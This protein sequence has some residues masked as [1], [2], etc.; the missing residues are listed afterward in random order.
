MARLKQQMSVLESKAKLVAAVVGVGALMALAQ[1]AG[2]AVYYWD[3]TATGL[4]ATG[5]DWSDAADSGGTTGVV[6]GAAD[7]VVFNQS[8]INGNETVQINA[9]TSIAG[10]TFANTGTTLVD[11]D[12]VT[13][14]QL[15][16][17][18]SGLTINAG[19]GAVTLGNAT[20]V[21]NVALN[22][23]QSW[24]NG[25]SSLLTIVNPLTNSVTTGTATLT[26]NGAGSGGTT[27]SGAINDNGT[28]KVAVNN[29]TTGGTTLF[30]ATSGYTGGFT[31]TGGTVKVA[32]TQRPLGNNQSGVTLNGGVLDLAAGTTAAQSIGVNNTVATSG[33]NVTVGGDTTI[34]SNV[35]SS[36]NGIA[37]NF[38]ALTIGGATLTV[39]KGSNVN[40]TGT[41]RVQFFS[42]LTLSANATFD[43]KGG[44][45][46]VLNN[47]PTGSSSTIKLTGNHDM[48]FKSSDGT[49]L[50]S[51]RAPNAAVRTGV[52]TLESGTLDFNSAKTGTF[53]GDPAG[54]TLVLN[55]G[56]LQISNA[57]GTGNASGIAAYNTTIGGNTT[58]VS[59][60]ATTAKAGINQTL[61][62]LAISANT[63][64]IKATDTAGVITSGTA[65]VQFGVTTLGGNATFN[66]IPGAGYAPTALTIAG[67]VGDA[68]SGYGITK[69]G[70]QIMVLSA[71]NTFSGNTRVT[72]GTL[73]LG[74]NL[75]LQNSAIDTSSVGT[76][77]LS[78]GITTPTFGGL[79]DGSGQR[80]LGSLITTGYS[81]VTSVTLNPGNGITNTYSGVIADGAAGM[82]LTKTGLGTQNLAGTST[83]TGATNITGGTLAITGSGSINGTSG[84]TVDGANAIFQYSSST[85]LSA[86]V[87]FGASGGKFIYDSSATFSQPLTV[88]TGSTLGGHGSLGIV[89]VSSGGILSPGNSPG[90]I[91]VG[92]LVLDSGSTSHM[93]I[94]GTTLGTQYDNVTITNNNGLTYGGLLEVVS[95]GGYDLTQVGSYNLFTL[96]S[97]T[98]SGDFS[99]V[100]VGGTSLSNSGGVWTGSSAGSTYQFT[101]AS[102]I[103]TVTIPEPATASLMLGVISLGLMARRRRAQ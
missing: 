70:A 92:T 5:A 25:S 22:G 19:A 75:A 71:A 94:A 56:T 26:L 14:R 68:G 51:L 90:Q 37:Y 54:A 93:E 60:A 76:I 80:A 36:A 72:A 12:S 20:N 40:N 47:D 67:A 96:N 30:S 15:N 9:T 46:L 89:T 53:L 6:P 77:T 65:G 13:A 91:T 74:N 27:F 42:S 78:G 99:N 102:G 2:A 64:T 1:P 33:Y 11:S 48:T 84:I 45:L 73:T 3:T 62:T 34:K 81:G 24:G 8:T 44:V 100:T 4:W 59:N 38:G 43:A 95:Y 88:A 83:Y 61:G 7:T 97:G 50:I 29:N 18:A 21:L 103:L 66:V 79:V 55:G 35:S 17:G 58:I 63:L 69:T 98:P 49:G 101:E 86:A 41:A 87:T 39:D 52:T 31:L 16:I 23:S 10:I 82:I 85:A 32:T 57:W 28:G